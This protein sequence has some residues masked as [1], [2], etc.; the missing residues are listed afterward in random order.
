MQFDDQFSRR[1]HNM[2]T[3]METVAFEGEN[4]LNEF[5]SNLKVVESNGRFSASDKCVEFV[6]I[7]VIQHFH[8]CSMAVRYCNYCH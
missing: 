4:L 3:L 8:R 7:S 2:K 5:V 1:I 6:D